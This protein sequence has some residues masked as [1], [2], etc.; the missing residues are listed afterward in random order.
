MLDSD[1]L[2]R[3]RRT[4]IIEIG[5]YFNSEGVQAIL[6]LIDLNYEEI[7]EGAVGAP[8]EVSQSALSGALSLKKLYADILNSRPTPP[9]PTT[10]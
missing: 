1:K 5:R 9:K 4:A 6:R 8:P 10:E 3:E 7:K 2:K